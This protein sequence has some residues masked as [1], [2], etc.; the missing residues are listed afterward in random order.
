MRKGLR[1]L[2][3]KSTRGGVEL[4]RRSSRLLGREERSSQ[5]VCG[6]RRTLFDRRLRTPRAWLSPLD[7]TTFASDE[8]PSREDHDSFSILPTRSQSAV[9]SRR[10]ISSGPMLGTIEH[11]SR[12]F[13]INTEN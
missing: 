10:L 11:E 5:H 3:C 12:A 9:P 2:V 13:D 1:M 6:I 7:N 8:A 4:G